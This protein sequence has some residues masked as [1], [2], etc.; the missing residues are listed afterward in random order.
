ML[1]GL[2]G[3]SARGYDQVLEFG[4]AENMNPDL[5]MAYQQHRNVKAVKSA[6]WPP[7]MRV[8]SQY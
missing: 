2:R 3:D 8:M 4:I 1:A 6:V 5:G 7:G